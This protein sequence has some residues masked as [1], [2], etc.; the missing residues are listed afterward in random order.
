MNNATTQVLVAVARQLFLNRE[1]VRHLSVR[2]DTVGIKKEVWALRHFGYFLNSFYATF[3]KNVAYCHGRPT[4]VC[5]CVCGVVNK[6]AFHTKVSLFSGQDKEIVI[7]SWE[8]QLLFR[9]CPKNSLWF[10]IIH[11]KEISTG[12]GKYFSVL[13]Q[14]TKQIRHK[15]SLNDFLCILNSFA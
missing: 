14:S 6:R 15:G 8:L 12:G 1:G 3:F 5:V 7:V 13:K 2:I 10:K 4:C 9:H 11:V